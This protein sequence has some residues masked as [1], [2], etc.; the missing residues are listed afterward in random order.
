VL[1]THTQVALKRVIYIY[2]FETIYLLFGAL[3]SYPPQALR[4]TIKS[5]SRIREEVVREHSK[6]I[7]PS[8][9]TSSHIRNTLLT[10]GGAAP[11]PPRLPWA[12]ETTSKSTARFQEEVVG[13]R[14]TQMEVKRVAYAFKIIYLLLGALPPDPR[15]CRELSNCASEE[16]C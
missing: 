5:G 2:A 16:M 12:I 11:K 6:R 10:V 9:T 3:H 14:Y 1:I 7:D 13:E 4:A 15:T 8:H